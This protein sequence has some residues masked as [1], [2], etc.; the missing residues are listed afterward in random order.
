[1][2]NIYGKLGANSRR[3][4]LIRAGELG[5]LGAPGPAAEHKPAPAAPET[6]RHNLPAQ[7]TRFFGRENEIAHLKDRL[8]HERL[9]TLTG[10]GGVGKTRLSLQAS[11]ALLP[12]YSDRVWFIA[13]A[14]LSDPALVAQT[15]ASTLGLRDEPG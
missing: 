8:R 13:L 4:E 15:V 14:P 10:S 1:T 2:Q 5:L 11:E 3:Q 7:V 9:V 12:E 6:S